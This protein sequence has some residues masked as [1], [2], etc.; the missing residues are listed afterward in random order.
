MVGIIERELSGNSNLKAKFGSIMDQLK[1]LPDFN[2]LPQKDVTPKPLK[3]TGEF[4][5]PDTGLKNEELMPEF[6]FTNASTYEVKEIE[7]SKEPAQKTKKVVE[8]E[9]TIFEMYY[10][11][12]GILSEEEWDTFYAKLKE[13]LDISFRINSIE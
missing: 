12:C 13:P 6:E 9:N 7:E 8:K 1:S 11:G 3:F 5:V 4:T 10:K 2:Y